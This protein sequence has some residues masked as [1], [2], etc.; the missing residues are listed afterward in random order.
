MDI[1]PNPIFT[2]SRLNYI[3]NI[4]NSG[5]NLIGREPKIWTRIFSVKKW[6][7]V[8]GFNHLNKTTTSFLQYFTF[9]RGSLSSL[10]SSHSAQYQ[11][12]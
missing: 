9:H 4:K 12:M 8:V 2:L 5:Q 1:V 6:R 10:P 7:V 11:I 3:F